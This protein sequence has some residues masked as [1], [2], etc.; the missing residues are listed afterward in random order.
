[1]EY[2]HFRSKISYIS[3]ETYIF[4]GSIIDNILVGN[5]NAKKEEIIN[6]AK[7]ANAND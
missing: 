7:I 2:N 6:T 3:Q 1:M 5:L 4:P